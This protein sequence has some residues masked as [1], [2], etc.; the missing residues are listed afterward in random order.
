MY[1]ARDG[2][3]GLKLIEKEDIPVV[4]GDVKL[5]DSNGVELVRK[6]KQLSLTSEVIN[7]TAFGN[8][9]EGVQAI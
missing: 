7:L 8:I 9:A 6:I 1:Q 2:K 3:S 5:P 4:L